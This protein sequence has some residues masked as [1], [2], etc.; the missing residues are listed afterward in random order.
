MEIDEYINSDT[1]D[2]LMQMAAEP[3]TNLPEMILQLIAI[4]DRAAQ[5]LREI[6][7]E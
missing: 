5:T 2:E 6:N 7:N 3:L 4:Q 1:Y